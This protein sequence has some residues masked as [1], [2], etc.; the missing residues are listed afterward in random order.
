MRVDWAV[1]KA[2]YD[3]I[4]SVYSPAAT[5]MVSNTTELVAAASIKETKLRLGVACRSLI[6]SVVPMAIDEVM[7]VTSSVW[8]SFYVITIEVVSGSPS[9][10]YLVPK[11]PT[12]QTEIPYQSG[13]LP[14]SACSLTSATMCMYCP[15]RLHQFSMP[16][17]HT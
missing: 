4:T 1:L 7:R 17:R 11:T 10:A 15:C 12:E 2:L 3:S 14:S 9:R 16:K 5:P 8:T 13:T 6:S